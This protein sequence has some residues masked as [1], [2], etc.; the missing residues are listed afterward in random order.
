MFRSFSRP[1][2]RVRVAGSIAASVA[3]A[4][5]CLVSVACVPDDAAW[6]SDGSDLAWVEP[7]DGSLR[8]WNV[9][10]GDVR[11]LHSSPGER[12]VFVHRAGASGAILF[13]TE[14]P[15]PDPNVA[16]PTRELHWLA[17]DG[18]L[19]RAI[20]SDVSIEAGA[21][22]SA[23]GGRVFFLRNAKGSETWSLW[24]IESEPPGSA[25]KLR[26]IL[27]RPEGFAYPSATA[28][29]RRVLL[30]FDRRIAELD[31][32]TGAL[33]TVVAATKELPAIYG[34]HLPDGER[35]AYIET[36]PKRETP[37][38]ASDLGRLVV[39]DRDGGSKRVLADGVSILRRPVPDAK[40]RL[41]AT[42]GR[43]PDGRDDLESSE[44][45]ESAMQIES[46]DARTGERRVLTDEPAGAWLPTPDPAGER[47]AYRVAGPLAGRKFE[48]MPIRVLRADG[49]SEPVALVPD[50]PTL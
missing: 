15:N 40:G 50:P 14:R 34:I 13:A 29:G 42:V 31:V 28:D 24:A 32:E 7:S 10:T 37:T 26:E 49:A 22:A 35:I 11:V 18:T 44:L 4:T 39:A 6:S 5:L 2:R 21:A 27:T 23:D 8:E 17:A 47:V 20:A 38:E 46:I 19:S 48:W 25:P 45:P 43:Y 1:G 9:A 30:T 41:W 3:A 12:V 16:D 33:R 36:K